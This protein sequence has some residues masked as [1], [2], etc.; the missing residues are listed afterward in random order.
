LIGWD[1]GYILTYAHEESQDVG[2][3]DNEEMDLNQDDYEPESMEDT[4]AVEDDDDDD[5]GN[6]FILFLPCDFLHFYIM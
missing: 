2:H 3:D 4:D 1:G 5:D 6:L